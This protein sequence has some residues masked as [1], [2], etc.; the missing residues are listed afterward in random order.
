MRAA[1]TLAVTVVHLSRRGLF[2]GVGA[3]LAAPALV[4]AT[5]IMPV[6]DPRLVRG[7]WLDTKRLLG[8]NPDNV[9]AAF[10]P[11]EFDRES[12]RHE[13]VWLHE[14]HP[15][16]RAARMADRYGSV[17]QPLID[18]TL[19]VNFNVDECLQRRHHDPILGARIAARQASVNTRA[20]ER[21]L[22]RPVVVLSA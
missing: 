6:R 3:L 21:S 16:V 19:A 7:I 22:H 9:Y 18:H 15:E 5:S 1:L 10:Q 12:L 20:I 14:S 8:G 4:R 2:G 17:M 13:V 11:L